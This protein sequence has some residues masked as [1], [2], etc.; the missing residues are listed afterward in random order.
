MLNTLYASHPLPNPGRKVLV[1]PYFTA[2]QTESQRGYFPQSHTDFY[3]VDQ[4]LE[5]GTYGLSPFEC[6]GRLG[7]ATLVV[8]R[9]GGEGVEGPYCKKT[10]DT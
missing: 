4:G 8:G 10:H 9:A 3:V 6:A 1:Y 5:L 7:K 2:E